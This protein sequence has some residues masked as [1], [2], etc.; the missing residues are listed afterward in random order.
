M[1]PA[2][3]AL[4]NAAAQGSLTGVAAAL[5]AGANVHVDDDAALRWAAQHSD[6]ELVARL[7]SAG[8]DVHAGDDAALNLA[9]GYHSDHSVLEQ[10]FGAGADV[11][12]VADTCERQNEVELAQSLRRA[13]QRWQ[14]AH[15]RQALAPL[16][17][18]GE[19]L[20]EAG[21]LGL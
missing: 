19:A 3:Q 4:L 18:A 14:G 8:A 16:S 1:R 11:A 9:L 20:P 17:D 7:L 15:L 13:H 6:P 21:C 2:D 5:A 12:K 10:L